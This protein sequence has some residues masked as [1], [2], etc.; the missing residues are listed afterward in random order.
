MI[1][2][3]IPIPIILTYIPYD[4]QTWHW[5]IL[6][7]LDLYVIF[8]LKPLLLGDFQSCLMTLE[9]HIPHFWTKP[10]LKANLAMLPDMQL[11]AASVP[12]LLLTSDAVGP[13]LRSLSAPWY[14]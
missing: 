13:N 9:G 1:I 11:A 12:G 6:S 2:V 4:D 5:K 10:L 8:P 3:P 14:Q 7:L